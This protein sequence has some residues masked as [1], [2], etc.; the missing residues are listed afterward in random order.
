MSALLSSDKCDLLLF[1]PRKSVDMHKGDIDMKRKAFD[2]LKEWRSNPHRKPLV[3]LGARQVGKTWLM[4]E[5]G[6]EFYDSVAYINCDAEPLAKELFVDDYNIERIL[7]SVQ[8]ITGVKPEPEKT[9]IIFDEIQEAPRGL[10]SLKY[11]QEEASEYHVMTAG[12]LLGITL[13]QGDSFPVGKVDM[14]SIYPL[15]F[16]EFLEAN[17]EITLLQVLHEGD[18]ELI[19][20][21]APKFIEQL[22]YYYFVGGMPEVVSHFISNKDLTEVR[23][24]QEDILSA[25]RSDISK[26]SSK[27]ESIRIGQVLESLPSQLVKENKKFIYG[28]I[29]KGARAKEFEVAIQWLMDAGIIHKVSRVKEIQMPVK[30]YED[31]SAFKLFLL[32]CGLFACMVDAPAKQM[33][34][35]DNVFKEFKG[36]FT[37]QFVLQQLVALGKTPYYWNSETT[38]AEIDFVVQDHDRVIPI[39]VKAEANVRSRSMRTYISS[40]PERGLKGLRI[41]MKGYKD[42]G[43][44]ENIPLYAI[45]RYFSD[46]R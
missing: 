7:F 27:T 16:D 13:H 8:A 14:L 31:L 1:Y 22:R 11:F 35:G 24:L 30:F 20:T 17:G 18:W 45:T 29:K 40:N 43:W 10:H 25:Y 36:T 15:D 46:N 5:F 28:V 12:S 26:H 37:E 34:V 2:H 23:R 39:E 4:K 3:L 9:L 42:Q 38:S 41:S 33:L 44:M 32:D 19:E 6:K 21:F